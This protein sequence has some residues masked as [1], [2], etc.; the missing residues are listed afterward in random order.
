[1]PQRKVPEVVERWHNTYGYCIE[2]VRTPM[3][4]PTGLAV[5]IMSKKGERFAT[6]VSQRKV[7]NK[8]LKYMCNSKT[9]VMR[10]SKMH[11]K[12]TFK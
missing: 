12:E 11:T 4:N 5:V 7:F 6:C 10:K 8:L 9:Y 1:M 2:S 3:T